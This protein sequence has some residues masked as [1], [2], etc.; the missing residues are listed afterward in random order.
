MIEVKKRKSEKISRRLLVEFN[1]GNE[2]RLI[3]TPHFPYFIN[4]NAP[5]LMDLA[6]KKFDIEEYKNSYEQNIIE[7]MQ[8]MG[9]GYISFEN[10]DY[11]M[12]IEKCK[13]SRNKNFE[14][15]IHCTV[16]EYNGK[17]VVDDFE[18]VNINK[19]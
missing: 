15:D 16:F 10:S 12:K 17:Y 19:E 13:H 1:D 3:I 4:T 9:K 6:T 8:Y 7:H 11:N 14:G 18:R 2:N 5:T